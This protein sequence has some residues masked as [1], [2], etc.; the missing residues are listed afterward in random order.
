M[1]ASL[2]MY[3]FGA[4]VAANDR[5]WTAVQAGLAARGIAAP[6]Q[7]TR[8]AAAYWPAWQAPDLILSQT[9]GYPYRA[10][11]HGRVQLVGTPDYRLPGCPAGHYNSVFVVRRDDPRATLSDFAGAAFAFNEDLSQSGWS[12][13]QNHAAQLGFYLQPRL[14]SGGHRLSAQAVAN[15]Q[16]DIAAIDAQTWELLRREPGQVDKLRELA[17]TEPTPA[18]P[19][20]TGL[21][22]NAALIAEALEAAIAGQSA[23][24]RAASG[25]Q[26]LVPLPAAAYL[27]VPSPPSPS[28]LGF[29]PE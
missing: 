11:L 12:A 24:D 1:I 23:Q 17:R 4:V 28:D 16:A 10:R 20:I 3:D 8:G 22:Q 13:P 27:A 5:L 15:G 29:A 21:T 14:R 7:L 19:F 25:L 2:G 9:C 18:L 6:D 26:G